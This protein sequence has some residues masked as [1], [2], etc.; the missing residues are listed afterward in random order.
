M[1]IDD[2]DEI[3][4]PGDGDNYNDVAPVDDP[5]AHEP[6]DNDGEIIQLEENGF[7]YYR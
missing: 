2:D 3:V 5:P 6:L 1:M 7:H 4:G